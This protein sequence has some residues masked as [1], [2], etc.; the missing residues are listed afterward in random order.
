MEELKF[1][2]RRDFL[3]K[4]SYLVGFGA[5]A[6]TPFQSFGSVQAKRLTILHTNDWHSRIEPFPEIDKQNAGKGGA[7]FRAALI[8][9]IRSEEENVLLLDSGDIFQG[10]PYFNFYGGEL[11]YKLMTQMGYDVV[12]LGN[13]D[14]DNGIEGII[15]QLPHAGFKI[16]NANYDFKNTAL[17]KVVLPFQIIKKAGLRIGI[18]GLG[19]ELAGLVPDKAFGKIVY[20]DPIIAAEKTSKYLREEKGCDFIIC[21]SHLGFNYN[22]KKASDMTLSTSNADVDL[23]LGGHTHTFL[24]EPVINT[25]KLGKKVVVNQVG[26]AGIKLGRI[27]YTF[28]PLVNTATITSFDSISVGNIQKI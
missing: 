26:W 13:H 20:N 3:K 27:D 11:E 9:K 24:T 2:S 25:N 4:T 21:L 12:T 23:V 6:N 18:F 5:L 7:A 14:F 1:N 22:G 10:T 19:I 8:K 28:E 17:E 15:K 16:V